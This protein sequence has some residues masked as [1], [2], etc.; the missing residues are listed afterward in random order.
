MFQ[1][2][3]S[4]CE[5]VSDRSPS[6]GPSTTAPCDPTLEVSSPDPLSSGHSGVVWRVAVEP[7]S[8]NG[9]NSCPHAMIA[10]AMIAGDHGRLGTSSRGVEALEQSARIAAGVEGH[11]RTRVPQPSS[12]CSVCC[13]FFVLLVCC[14][15]RERLPA[16]SH[17]STSTAGTPPKFV[18]Q[19]PSVFEYDMISLYAQGKIPRRWLSAGVASAP[20]RSTCTASSRGSPCTVLGSASTS[21]FLSLGNRKV[22]RCRWLCPSPVLERPTT[23]VRTDDL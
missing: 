12:I 10:G 20:T 13:C 19:S 15:R 16:P 1:I 7:F 3:G 5:A 4:Y 9:L 14:G 22:A 11:Q 6:V 17:C 21:T 2:R 8:G 18:H 23:T